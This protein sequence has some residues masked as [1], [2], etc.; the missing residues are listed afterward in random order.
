MASPSEE[1]RVGF[2]AEKLGGEAR[3]RAWIGFGVLSPVR[4][5]FAPQYGYGN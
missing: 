3:E 4:L 1:R 5:S 2:E